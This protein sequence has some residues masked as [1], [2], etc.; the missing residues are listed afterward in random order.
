[1]EDNAKAQNGERKIVI[2]INGQ[3]HSIEKGPITYERV[4]ELAYDGN[5]P[6]AEYD[7]SVTYRRGQSPHDQGEL[8]PGE[9]VQAV[10]RMIFNVTPTKKS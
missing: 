2:I 7:F 1:M 10:N 6:T 9:S 3:E 5:P 8:D 4:V